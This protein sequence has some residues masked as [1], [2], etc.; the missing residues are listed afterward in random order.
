MSGERPISLNRRPE[1]TP[2]ATHERQEEAAIVDELARLQEALK[3]FTESEIRAGIYLKP[4]NGVGSWTWCDDATLPIDLPVI[5]AEMKERFGPGNYEIRIS[6]RGKVRANSQFTIAKEKTPPVAAAPANPPLSTSELFAMMI[7]QQEN[8][9]RDASAAADRQMTMI[10]TMMTAIIPALAGR[11]AGT[12]PSEL[13]ALV[14]ALRREGG[15]MK[16]TVETLAAFRTLI[17]G[18]GGGD[19]DGKETGLDVND[20]VGSG[21]R[22][23]GPAMRAI[24][25]LISQRRA[26]SD[27]TG[28]SASGA[29]GPQGAPDQLAL[30]HAPSRFRVI[31]L[32][33]VD[34]LYGFGRGHDAAKVADLVYDVIEAN[35]V[36]EAEI[37][38]LAAAFALSPTGLDD[39][40]R[41]G[42]DLRSNPTW[43]AE[44]FSELHAI[45][46]GAA[47]DLDGDNGSTPDVGGN[48][49]AGA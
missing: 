26:G 5:M 29:G 2:F 49:E 18:D 4:H 23:V 11:Q 32:V 6:A 36:T 39:L 24:G 42:I 34:I 37:D 46:T 35:Q 21:A 9:R 33:K 47:D 8:A 12:S 13:A 40:A 17:Q 16:E 19:G 28:P 3:D 31:E 7:T 27:G 38:E 15:G 43:A 25:D 20:L 45:H 44:F 1:V 22:L 41:E 48:G 14:T 10:T 30:G